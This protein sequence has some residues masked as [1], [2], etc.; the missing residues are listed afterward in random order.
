[1]LCPPSLQAALTV[2][3]LRDGYEAFAIYSFTAFLLEAAGGEAA[4][5][6]RLRAKPASAGRHIFP[7]NH[8]LQP[9]PLGAVLLRRCKAGVL[10][11]V[12]VRLVLTAVTLVLEGQG[13]FAE[14][15]LARFDRGYVYVTAIANMSQM[16]AV[17]C[18]LLLLQ[19]AHEELTPVRAWPKLLC[20]KAVI[21]FV[22]WQGIALA[23]LVQLGLMPTSL[24]WTEQEVAKGVQNLLIVLEMLPAALAH[25]W[26][27]PV[28]DFAPPE[29]EFV[30]VSTRDDDDDDD[31]EDD[32]A[33]GDGAPAAS[34]IAG[35]GATEPTRPRRKPSRRQAAK[36]L[37][38]AAVSRSSDSD[39][40]SWVSVDL[41]AGTSS[42]GRGSAAEAGAGRSDEEAPL[43]A[44]SGLAADAME[45]LV[46]GSGDDATGASSPAG[47]GGT[48]EEGWAEPRSPVAGTLAAGDEAP[49][50][51]APSAGAGLAAALWASTIPSDV[52]SEMRRTVLPTPARTRR[53]RARRAR[54]R[55]AAHAP[56]LEA[57]GSAAPEAGAS[58]QLRGA[59][60]ARSPGHTDRARSSSKSSSGGDSEE[61]EDDEASREAILHAARHM[62]AAGGRTSGG[63]VGGGV[64]P[65]RFATRLGRPRRARGVEASDTAAMAAAAATFAMSTEVRS[66]WSPS[67]GA[68]D[69]SPSAIF[70]PLAPVT[71]GSTMAANRVHLGRR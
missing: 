64:G 37:P 5:A 50:P 10:Q 56:Q 69:A 22:W 27:F 20:V 44:G 36:R 43:H 8:C 19:A 49:A 67:T 30:A 33:R 42:T 7:M 24:G 9:W 54:A 17:Y 26:A 48:A 1:M 68:Q 35:A 60:G 21:F 61:G 34:R 23:V 52:V 4:L 57:A 11:Y 63:G 18:L 15:E 32:A 12:V 58:D 31:G 29:R 2:E 55:S 6:A 13:V 53:A 59:N 65:L 40:K 45:V 41:E 38:H 39:C 62:Q 47:H 3:T 51:V 66:Q 14:G 16:T 25:R 28:S 46:G 71:G 70:A